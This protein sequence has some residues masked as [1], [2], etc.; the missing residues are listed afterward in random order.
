MSKD[1]LFDVINALQ[2]S[3][4]YLCPL[5]SYVGAEVIPILSKPVYTL[6]SGSRGKG[7]S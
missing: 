2:I 4:N 5:K 7:A 1:S 6:F 3:F